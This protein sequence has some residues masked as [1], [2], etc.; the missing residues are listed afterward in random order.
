M[1]SQINPV[2]VAVANFAE[3]YVLSAV[4][5]Y[6]SFSNVIKIYSICSG[7]APIE[8]T[9]F[10]DIVHYLVLFILAVFTSLMLLLA[11]RPDASPPNWRAI[12]IPLAT[13]FYT[14]LYST[15][16]SFP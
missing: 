9:L 8:T 11:R 5:L 12:L 13:T 2:A 16:R 3:R 1:T 10:I 14:V 7:R 4:F 15:A 6:L